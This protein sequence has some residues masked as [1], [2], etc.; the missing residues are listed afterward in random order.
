MRKPFLFVM[1]TFA[2]A[3]T[4]NKII[5]SIVVHCCAIKNVIIS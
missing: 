1:M 3:E 4:M 2:Q 5:F